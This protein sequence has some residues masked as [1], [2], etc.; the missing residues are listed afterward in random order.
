[1]RV[2]VLGAGSWGTGLG[3]VLARNGH[4]VALWDVDRPVLESIRAHGENTRYLPGV[5]LPEG[6]SANDDLADATTDAELVVVVVP[7]QA[8]RSVARAVDEHL[9]PE[10]VVCCAAKGVELDTLALMSEVLEEELPEAHDRLA[11]L[12]GPSFAAE[13]VRDH[14]TAVTV[15]SR[16]AATACRV[17]AAFASRSFRPY[18]T[19]DVVGVE[20]GG[21]VKNVIA[22]GAGAAA[23]LGFGAN[24]SA[25]LITRGLAEISRLA[26]RLGAE[27]AT[28]GGLAGLG[29]LVLT[30]SSPLSRNYRV[31][32]GIGQGRRLEE[33]QAELGQ[34]AE[35]VV[36]ARS[37]RA[38][39]ER[40]DVEMPICDTV[41]RLLFEG[42]SATDAVAELMLRTH[43]PE[44]DDR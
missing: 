11:Y 30:C 14:P 9:G 40:Y 6:L 27:A 38:M 21:C 24:A 28:L 22:I 1:M 42:L 16:S 26:V 2:A 34:V 39:A 37:V 10:A 43:R 29:D 33:V 35:G 18:T 3:S 20:V 32:Y 23:G 12:S 7:S 8:V 36:N 17:Q 19:T 31:G 41:H 44:H 4:V 15:A 5:P 25:A 13:V